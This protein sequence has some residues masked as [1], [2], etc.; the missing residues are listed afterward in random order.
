VPEAPSNPVNAVSES[1]QGDWNARARED[2]HYYVAFGRKN[3][4]GEGFFETGREQVHG[5]ELELRRLAGAAPYGAALEIGCGP[6]RLLRPMAAHF[7]EIHGIDVSDEMIARA[8]ENLRG[9]PNAHAHHSPQSNLDPVSG[10]AFDFIYSY[11]VFQHIP[12]REVVLGY[13]RQAA[14]LLRPGGI[15]RAQLNGLP[16]DG[17]QFTT[18]SGV[19]IE[20]E[21]IATFAREQGLQLLALEG[22]GTQY[23]WTTLRK[24]VAEAADTDELHIRRVTNAYSGEP[25]APVAGRFAAL[26]LGVEGLHA[27]VGLNELVVSVEGAACDLTY[28]GPL[29]SDGLHQ[30]NLLL[31]MGLG[32]GLGKIELRQTGGP[33]ATASIRLI[34]APPVVVKLLS[35]TDGVDLVSGARIT[36]GHIKATIEELADPARLRIELGG[37]PIERFDTFRTDPRLPK[38]EVNF[39]VPADFAHGPARVDIRMGPRLVGSEVVEIMGAS[40]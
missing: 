14:R 40:K 16:Q 3:Q 26:S 24:P 8:R 29:D 36:S 39:A 23:M 38:W 21:A 2:A 19:R 1:M 37:A 18:W 12:S 5:L 11:A 13:L 7:R 20:A 35:V 34:P 6:G 33:G 15:V 10:I 4:D 32:T 28:L 30:L 27:N 25:V 31:P 17:V 9:T 22:V